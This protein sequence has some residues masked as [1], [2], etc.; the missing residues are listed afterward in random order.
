MKASRFFLIL[1]SSILISNTIQAQEVQQMNPKE[2]INSLVETEDH[3]KVIQ[4]IDSLRNES[5]YS[6]ELSWQYCRALFQSGRYDQAK[7]SLLQWAGHPNYITQAQNMLT[8][9]AFQQHEYN[10]SIDYLFQLS[11]RF[12]SNPIYPFRL[13]KAFLAINQPLNALHQLS[14][15]HQIDTLNQLIISEW[16]DLL[17]TLEVYDDAFEILNKGLKLSPDNVSFLQQKTMLSYRLQ[18]HQET[19]NTTEKLLLLG[20]TTPQMI[21]LMAVA[22]YQIDSIQK[23]EYWIDYLLAKEMNAEDISFYKGKILSMSGRKEEAQDYY[24]QAILFCLS[25]NFSSFMNQAGINLYEQRKYKESAY[26]F[27]TSRFFSEAPIQLYYLGLNNYH[28]YKNKNK[29]K[30]FLTL[31]IE[32]STKPSEELIKDHAKRLIREIDEEN[33]FN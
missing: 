20:D 10:E 25:P 22:Y 6:P 7:D 11:A 18:N 32:Q 3:I 15:A 17:I 14:V 24:Y 27:E 5:Y 30:E 31:F 1:I 4:Y 12:P 16:V 9:I 13:S 21:K 26:L 2:K 29:A 8:Q 28:L 23:S 19:I 33:H